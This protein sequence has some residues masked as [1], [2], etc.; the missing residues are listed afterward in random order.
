MFYILHKELKLT[1]ITNEVCIR[2][3]YIKAHCVGEGFFFF[4]ANF[5]IYIFLT[6]LICIIILGMAVLIH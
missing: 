2:K 1:N 3:S 6:V 5:Y 4:F